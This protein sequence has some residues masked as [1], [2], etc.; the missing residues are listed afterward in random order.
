MSAANYGT[1]SGT[2]MA[3]PH[4]AGAAALLSS[5]NPDLSA[6]SLKATLMNSV[7]QLVQWNG[8]VKMG[9]RLNISRALSNQT[10][11]SFQNSLPTQFPSAG[12]NSSIDVTAAANCDFSVFSSVPWITITS[13]AV[14]SG[15]TTVQYSVAPNPGLRRSGSIGIANSI[16]IISQS[17]ALSGRTPLDFDAD[18]KT[19]FSA[20][21]NAAGGMYWYNF[22]SANGYAP[23]N[24]GLFADD[25]PVPNDFDGDGKTD[26]AVWRNSSGI[27]YVLRS[28]DGTVQYTR[29]GSSGDD[30]RTSQDFDGDGKSDFVVTRVENGLLIWYVLKS[31]FFQT[32]TVIQFGLQND[33]P[34]RGD[35]DGDGKADFAVYR[36]NSGSPANTFF[37]LKS[38]SGALSVVT[39][40]IS[41]IDKIVTGDF[42]GDAKTD[43]AVW[44]N[45]DGNW[46]YLKST[47]GSY[48]VYPFGL[49]TDLPVPGDYDGDG[50]TDFAVWRPNV[51]SGESG[52]FYVQRTTAGFAAFGW[53]NSQMNIPANTMQI[54]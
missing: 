30:P 12:G 51:N 34:L 39:F 36:P 25:I 40:G 48:N 4:V 18:G 13:G 37:V 21:Q 35:F 8:I 28:S 9:G 2:S 45:T 5:Y 17:G 31:G 19:D 16:L 29:W 6:A 43:F 15:N 42:D 53:G 14:G 50:K 54:R 47:D 3:T 1:L 24:F 23:A 26:I 38:Q 20:I 33:R 7:D 32:S 44:R 49:G 22:G 46:H 11:C 10:T 27:F 52:N 41:T